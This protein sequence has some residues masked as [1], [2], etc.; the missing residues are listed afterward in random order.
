MISPVFSKK[1]FRFFQFFSKEFWDR[2]PF[3][4]LFFLKKRISLFNIKNCDETFTKEN[5]TNFCEALLVLAHKNRTH[6][7]TMLCLLCVYFEVPRVP[8]VPFFFCYTNHI[9][10]QLLNG[11]FQEKDKFKPHINLHLAQLWTPG[12]HG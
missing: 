5:S 11:I 7:K 9:V 10:I 3:S 6:T 8:K 4:R 2:F 1:K 12:A